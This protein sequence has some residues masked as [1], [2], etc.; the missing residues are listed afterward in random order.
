MPSGRILYSAYWDNGPNVYYSDDD[1][2]TWGLLSN[3]CDDGSFSET[4]LT[5]MP[6]GSVMSWIRGE[7]DGD[8]SP[9]FTAGGTYTAV[10]SDGG[11]TWSTPILRIPSGGDGSSAYGDTA[12]PASMVQ[13]ASGL[14]IVMT[15]C[16]STTDAD[17]YAN[18][19]AVYFTQD[20]QTF[21]GP[22]YPV[23]DWG[24]WYG[25]GIE[26]SG[27]TALFAYNADAVPDVFTVI[28]PAT[29]DTGT[30]TTSL[31]ADTNADGTG[32]DG[33]G[34]L[35]I[36]A[37]ATVV[38]SN[39]TANAITLRG[40]DIEIDTSADPATIGDQLAGGVVIRSSL[41]SRPMSLG[42]GDSDVQG[43]NLTDAELARIQTT[44]TGTVTIGDSGQIGSITFHT[45]TVATTAGASTCVVQ[46][47]AGP[48]QIILMTTAADRERRRTAMAEASA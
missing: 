34:T 12:G 18:T 15:R 21:S 36:G 46:D 38:S 16:Y 3:I 22:F 35:S 39:A 9:V 5:L 10:S 20:V 45:A 17:G 42:G 37:G 47:P 4:C 6:G 23:P 30:G 14:T 32:N 44:D 8:P 26:L 25:S 48:G 2:V 19:C 24:Y 29:F 41:P 31:A 33:V 27:S 28:D 1:G 11:A 7:S 43:I 40:A 13:L